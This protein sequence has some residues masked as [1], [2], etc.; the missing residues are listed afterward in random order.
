M[1][2]RKLVAI[3][4]IVLGAISLAYKGISYK[5][6]EEILRVGEFRATAVTKKNIPIPRYLGFALLASGVV[7]LAVRKKS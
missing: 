1:N 4:L 5:S 7:L 2:I 6:R 3:G